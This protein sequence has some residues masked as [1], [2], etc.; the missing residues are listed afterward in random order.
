MFY[1]LLQSLHYSKQKQLTA[2]LAANYKIDLLKGE[3]RHTLT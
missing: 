2:L 1:S 3:K